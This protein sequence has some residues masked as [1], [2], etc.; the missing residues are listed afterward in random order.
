[1]NF[2]ILIQIFFIN[3]IYIMINTIRILLTMKGYRRAAPLIAIVEI[4]IYTLG[5]SMVMQ[6]ISQPIYLITY[7]VGFGVGIYFGILLEDRLA[8]GYS[9][10][11]IFTHNN[12]GV[13]A[14]K[15]RALGYGVTVQE[16]FGRDG[17]RAVLTILTPRKNETTLCKTIDALEPKVFYISY[18]AKYV[19]G[20]FWTKRINKHQIE[21]SEVLI[22]EHDLEK[23]LAEE[24]MK[25]ESEAKRSAADRDHFSGSDFSSPIAGGGGHNPFTEAA[26]ETRKM[27]ATTSSTLPEKD[28]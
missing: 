19:K 3:L 18:S 28:E 5:L 24:L 25:P 2:G 8:L 4:T 7:A 6:Y 17:E 21:E 10:I 1:M 13:L 15:L 12:G 11:Q 23:T 20:G 26:A 14:L 9:V 27:A 16:G 22:R